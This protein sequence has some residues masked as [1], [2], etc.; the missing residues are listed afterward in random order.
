MAPGIFPVFFNG[1]ITA[2]FKICG[3]VPVA[4][5]QLK[6]SSSLF[7][8]RGPSALM[9]VGGISSG[10]GAPFDLICRIARSSSDGWKGRQQASSTVG[11]LRGFLQLTNAASF[12]SAKVPSVDGC[13][14]FH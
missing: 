10:S 8:A 5:L 13:V 4:K 9:K 11:D 2:L 1:K 6:I 12:G 3:E 14:G 7:F